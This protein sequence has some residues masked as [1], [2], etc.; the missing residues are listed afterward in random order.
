M[1]GCGWNKCSYY[2]YAKDLGLGY[3]TK[4]IADH[5]DH[6]TDDISL[7]SPPE[8]IEGHMLVARAKWNEDKHGT[9]DRTAA[10]KMMVFPTTGTEEPVKQRAIYSRASTAR[11]LIWRPQSR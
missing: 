1:I 4:L 8:Q 6:D 10:G 11:V 5:L 3:L 9:G 2:G 7:T